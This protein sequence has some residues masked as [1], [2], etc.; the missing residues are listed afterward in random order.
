MRLLSRCCP[1]AAAPAL[2]LV[3]TLLALA[4]ASHAAVLETIGDAHA[5][6]D[7]RLLYREQHLIRRDGDRPLERLV[8]YRCPDGTAFARKRVDYRAS[9]LAPDFALVDARGYRE[10]LRRENGQARVWHDDAAARPLGT[11]EATLVADAG[12]D[13]FIRQRWTALA[14]GRTQA[15]AFAIPALGRSLSFKVRNAG[16]RTPT[17]RRFELKAGG[18][19]GL[20]A[21]AIAVD[22]DPRDRR[23]RRFIGPT[24]IRDARGKQIEA[25]IE[26]AQAPRAVDDDALW[27]RLATLPLAACTLGP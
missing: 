6:D 1:P 18:L 5:R 19:V 15:L 16:D 13:E 23:L 11:P 10:G 4:P 22:Y 2:V 25:R 26:F 8:L 17:A 3:A 24:N 9:T 27:R 21:P 12:F 20:V 7:G 14:P